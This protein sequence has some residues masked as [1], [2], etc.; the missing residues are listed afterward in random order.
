[1]IIS[2][3]CDRCDIEEETEDITNDNILKYKVNN[4]ASSKRKNEG[5][6]NKM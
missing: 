2:V 6:K 1:V 3:L 4:A 5:R